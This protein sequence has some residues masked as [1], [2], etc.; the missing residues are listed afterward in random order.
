MILKK[1]NGDNLRFGIKGKT[2]IK[3][4]LRVYEG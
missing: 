2:F 3:D 4:A 1:V